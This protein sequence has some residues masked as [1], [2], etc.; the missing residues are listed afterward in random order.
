[1]ADLTVVAAV[2]EIEGRILIGQRKAGSRHALK[3][4]FPGGKVEPNEE[5]RSALARE[6]Q[7]E[8]SIT[9]QIGPELDRYDF[10]YG[11]GPLTELVFFHVTDFTGQIQN[12][13][14]E[15]IAWARRAELGSFDFLEGDLRF[16]AKLQS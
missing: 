15:Q 14:F 5:L 6:L 9:A 7:E 10:R 12:L 1:M 3:W 8:L 4:E 16:L 13:A 11:N 2:L